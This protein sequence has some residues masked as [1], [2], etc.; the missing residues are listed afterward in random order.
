MANY[1]FSTVSV[2]DMANQ[3]VLGGMEPGEA[4]QKAK[5]EFPK[6]LSELLE[7]DWK[8]LVG[9]SDMVYLRRKKK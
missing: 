9:D 6:R 8:I 3:F 5:E 7:Q 4:V 1:E 2:R